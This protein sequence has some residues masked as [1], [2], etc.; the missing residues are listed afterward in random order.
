MLG[1]WEYAGARP[2]GGEPS[3]SQGFR[4]ALEIDS[5]VADR[6]RGRVTLWFA[7]DVGIPRQAFGP[8]EGTVRADG[9]VTLVIP[10]AKASVEPVTIAGRLTG[11]GDTLAIGAS[12]R[13]AEPGP[14]AAAAG[15]RFVRNRPR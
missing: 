8:V 11:G 7:G 5:A 9:E 3:L 10:Y 2:A 12:R 4:V 14:F 1:L 13:G 15:S 6:F